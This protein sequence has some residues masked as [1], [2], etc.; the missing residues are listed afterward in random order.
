M[1]PGTLAAPNLFLYFTRTCFTGW[2]SLDGALIELSFNVCSGKE[3]DLAEDVFKL[4]HL[5]E[6]NIL[7]KQEAVEDLASAALKEEAIE[8]KLAAIAVEWG[9]QTFTFQEYKSRGPVVLKVS[10]LTPSA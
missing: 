5:L 3:L 8:T 10:L 2:S 6:A 9:E 1:K 4:G 7:T